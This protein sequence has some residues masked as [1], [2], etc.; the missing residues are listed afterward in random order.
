MFLCWLKLVPI[1]ESRAVKEEK[2]REGERDRGRKGRREGGR[3]MGGERERREKGGRE[4]KEGRR[5][6]EGERER[7]EVSIIITIETV[8]NPNTN[9]AF[10]CQ[11]LKQ[12]FVFE[13]PK[14]KLEYNTCALHYTLH[15]Q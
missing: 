2:R 8:P 6:E 15:V 9:T 12:K 1:S 5:R 3:E 10:H 14:L 13:C 7:G 4:K 11:N